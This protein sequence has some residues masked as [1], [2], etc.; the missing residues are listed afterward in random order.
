MHRALPLLLPFALVACTPAGTP[1]PDTAGRAADAPAPADASAAAAPDATLGA[2]HWD[3]V[4]ARTRED[5]R[6]DGLLDHAGTPLRLDFRDGSVSV[7]NACNRINGT[8]HLDGDRMTIDP[9]VSTMM[10]CVDDRLAHLDRTIGQRL[11]GA[12]RV[13]VETGETPRLTLT[14]DDGAVLR[15][16]G[17]P[18]PATR[19]GH[20]GEQMFLEIAPERV[21]CARPL[22]PD[23]RCLQTRPAEYDADGVRTP[24]TAEWT[25][26]YQE[27]EGFEHVDGTRNIV[28]VQRFDVVDPPADA[29]SQAYV[30]DMV[31]E[32]EITPEADT[33]PRG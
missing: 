23:H 21:A 9:M 4:E 18:T 8:V 10:A 32:S 20:D 26:L 30:L 27:I 12:H 33:A 28:R 15:F 22:M 3:L 14:A 13:A 24:T 16:D 7:S 1:P 11:P 19:Y 2:Y 29:P 5:A 25:P 31:V 6:I 17:V